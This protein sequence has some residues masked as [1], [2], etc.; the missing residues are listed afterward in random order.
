MNCCQG[1]FICVGPAIYW[2]Y[3][4]FYFLG[5]GVKS[6]SFILFFDMKYLLRQIAVFVLINLCLIAIGLWAVDHFMPKYERTCKNTEATFSAIGKGQAYDVLIFGTSHAR[7]FS[8]SSNHDSIEQIIGKRCF[9]LGKGEGHGGI[10]PSV[11]L[12]QIFKQRGN[13]AK[14]CIYFMD[15]WVFYSELWNEGNYFLEDEPLNWDVWK[16]SLMSGAKPEVLFNGIRSKLKPS[17]FMSREIIPQP[18]IDSLSDLDP[19]LV[20]KQKDVCYPDGRDSLVL[21]K[22]VVRFVKLI[23]DIEASGTKVTVVIPPTLLGKDPGWDALSQQLYMNGISVLDH[24][25]AVKR[26]GFYYDTNHLNSKGIGFYLRT[27]LKPLFFN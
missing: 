23:R 16:V 4:L 2:L 9:N 10:V 8:R 12:W 18:N 26:I 6:S 25:E 13:A 15:P 11:A 17:F 22:Y 24:T 1:Q 14:E 19:K 3:G 27:Q 21:R 20:Q 7:V 5:F